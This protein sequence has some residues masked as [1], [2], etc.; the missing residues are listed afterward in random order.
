MFLP[1]QSYSLYWQLRLIL[2]NFEGVAGTNLEQLGIAHNLGNAMTDPERIIE[3]LRINNLLAEE[4][5]MELFLNTFEQF[6]TG[7]LHTDWSNE[8]IKLEESHPDPLLLAKE[9]LSGYED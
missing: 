7:N 5:M 6:Y 4:H 9:I 3:I 1:P 8:K 2:Q